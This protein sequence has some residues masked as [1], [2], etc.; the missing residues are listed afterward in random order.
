MIPIVIY[1]RKDFYLLAAINEKIDILKA[2][3]LITFW[4]FKG[5]LNDVRGEM[6]HPPPVLTL[7][8]FSGSFHILFLG[9]I[10]GLL[11]FAGELSCSL[12][13]RFILLKVI[14]I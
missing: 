5:N 1:A 6:K 2:A 7:K 13:K 8:H 12:M 9:F 3:G 11:L 4:S 14:R 10:A